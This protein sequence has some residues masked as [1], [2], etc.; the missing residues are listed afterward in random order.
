MDLKRGS[1]LLMHITSLPGPY[2]IGDIGPSAR[3]FVDFLAASGQRYWQFLPLN[4]TS[5]QS[6]SSPYTS[7]AVF[8]GNPLLISPEGLVEEGLLGPADLEQ[9]PAFSDFSVEFP[10]V[11][12]FKTALLEKAFRTFARRGGN[13]INYENFCQEEKQWLGDYALFMAIKEDNGHKP[14]HRWPNELA[15]RDGSALSY[16]AA[17]LAERI[18]FYKFSQFYFFRQWAQLRRYSKEH[19][20]VLI[21]DMPFYVAFDSA[22]VW[23]HQL[24]FKIDPESLTPTH[25]SGVPPDYFS[26]T[27]QLWGTPVYEWKADSRLNQELYQW[28]T[29]RFG[30]IF[31]T[32]DLARVDHFRGFAAHWEVPVEEKTAINGQWITGPG[33]PFF[34]NMAKQFDPFG[35]IAEDLGTITPDVEKLKA[36]M[37]F[38]GMKVLQFAFDSDSLNTHL[39][40]NFESP[41]CVVYTGTHDNDTT[42]GWYWDGRVEQ[43]SK[44]RAL[45]YA[46]SRDGSNIHW[47]FIRMAY[48]STAAAAIIPMQDVLGFGN[49]CRMNIPNVAEGN[50]GWRCAPQ[51]FTPDLAGRL[52]EESRFYGRCVLPLPPGQDSGECA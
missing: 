18:E 46:N 3:A 40:H 1:G 6:A 22:D 2:G 47:D 44:Q 21:G 10:R 33:L 12:P 50:W 34:R 41:N 29:R 26:A 39:P 48:S 23:A 4:P 16:A 17:K 20:I 35:I 13:H 45:R 7:F 19:G 32:V 31:R 25:V 24:C 49:D 9:P 36:G 28:W 5:E 27:G 30:Q 8:A 11:A 52:R 15:R 51:Y 38:P 14:W 37:G 43:R 42:V